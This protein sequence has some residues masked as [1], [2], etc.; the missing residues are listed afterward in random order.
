LENKMKE[1]IAIVTCHSHKYRDRAAAC[2]VTWAQHAEACG[3]TLKFFL[4]RAPSG[5]KPLPDEV[6]L[7]VR[8]GYAD[9]PAKVQAV[10]AWALEQGFDYVFKTDDDV[11]LNMMALR[12]AP[13]APHDYVGRFRGASGGYPADYAS[14]YGYW[15]SRKAMELIVAAKLTDDTAE[16][17]WVANTLAAA[18]VAGYSDDQSYL[19][20]YP[21]TL[22]EMVFANEIRNR[23]AWCEYPP[24]LMRRMYQLH[25]STKT[26]ARP[27]ILRPVPLPRDFKAA[28]T[29]TQEPQ[30]IIIERKRKDLSK[31]CVLI[32]TF[33]RDG[34]LF[35]CVAGLERHFP[36][37]RM[38]IMDDGR[39]APGKDAMYARLRA[40]GHTCQ[41]MTF[42]SGFGA[43]SNAAIAHY[44]RP[45]VLIASDDFDFND[46]ATR[47]GVEMM[48]ELLDARED[49]A[50]ASGRV[51]NNPY[52]AMLQVDGDTVAEIPL[53]K[54]TGSWESLEPSGVRYH[55]CDLT[56]NYSV[57]RTSVLGK[58]PGKVKW[59]GGKVKIGGGEHGAFYLDLK[60]EG[61]KVAIVA[62]ANV[63][64]L[65][66]NPAKQDPTYDAM[67][68]RAREPGRI[69]LRRRGFKRWILQD[70][71]VEI[72]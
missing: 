36:E 69:C 18:G 22:P 47:H 70:G 25:R 37:V 62:G 15:L 68:G 46:D 44:D 48:T 67:R 28:Q 19:A 34:Y 49:I 13:H 11:Y 20:C 57:I 8:D 43:K 32:K 53:H 64:T 58:G 6:F 42:D 17:R 31:L 50:V 65:R 29:L 16:D 66:Y 56:V 23:V 3:Y 51:A 1:L 61:H 4:G 40:A 38:V 45:Y 30:P 52:E 41:Y 33:L 71:T 12:V 14:G 26:V 9:M 24:D 54:A 2:R 55:L 21:P 39:P 7:D 5:E 60:S 35:D 59:D 72:V 10:Y 63:E 27:V